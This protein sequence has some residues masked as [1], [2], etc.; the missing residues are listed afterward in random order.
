MTDDYQGPYT[1]GHMKFKAIQDFSK[2]FEKEIQDSFNDMCTFK[3]SK[4]S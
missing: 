3:C 2:V 1:H 4:L